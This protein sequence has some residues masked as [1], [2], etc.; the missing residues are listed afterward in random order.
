M[1]VA[2]NGTSDGQSVNLSESYNVVSSSS[3]EI[4]VDVAYSGQANETFSAGLL[5]NGTLSWFSFNGQNESGS[6]E[7]GAMAIGLFA[8]FIFEIDYVDS[9]SNFTPCHYLDL[10][11]I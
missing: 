1:K 10:W 2:L 8:G 5:T 9:L 3:S 7:Y 4:V 6:G 11:R